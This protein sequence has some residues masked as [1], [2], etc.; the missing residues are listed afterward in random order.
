ML[1]VIARAPVLPVVEQVPEPVSRPPI[2]E[3]QGETV[4]VKPAPEPGWNV[5]PVN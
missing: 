4:M 3:L 5:E 1:I 2:A